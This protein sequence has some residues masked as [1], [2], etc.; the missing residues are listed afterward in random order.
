VSKTYRP[1]APTQSLL[2]PTSPLDW[3]PEDHLARFIL[4]TVAELDLSVIY[5]YYEREKRGFPP[6][7]PQ[8][9]VALL[10]YAYCVG[11]PSS[12][13]IAKKTHEDVAFRVL[14]GNTH[15]DYSR[16]SEFRR[17]HQQAL[18]GLFVQVLRM[19]QRMGLVKLGHVALDGTKIKANASKHKAM[20]YERMGKEVEKLE[21]EVQKLMAAAEQ[22]DS[23]ED[24]EYGAGRR[25]DELPEELRR[26]EGRLARIRALKAELLAEAEQQRQQREAQQDEAA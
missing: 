16:I 25:G 15:P 19:C 2:L 11:V 9:M 10:L 1:Y 13:K 5:S 24:S 8:M 20:S 3:L 4:D 26:R 18:S 14:A 23:A 7:H 21:A 17:I 22:A 6:H 12:R